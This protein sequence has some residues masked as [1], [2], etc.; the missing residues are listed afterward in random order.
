MSSQ[1]Q[2]RELPLSGPDLKGLL[3]AVLAKGAAFRF[4]AKGASMAP[5]IRDGDVVTVSPVPGTN[6]RP[7]D[8]AA[9]TNPQTDRLV[10]HRI[11]GTADGSFLIKG[12]SVREG[13]V[14]VPA[15]QVH[16]RVTRVER[17]GRNLRLGLGSERILIAFLSRTGLLP[18]LLA[19]VRGIYRLIVPRNPSA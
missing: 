19:P 6:L 16:G 1:T 4:R 2:P 7:G 10:I 3:S 12:D 14:L 15:C 9:F 8:V 11:V 18:I 5:F 13:D 17:K